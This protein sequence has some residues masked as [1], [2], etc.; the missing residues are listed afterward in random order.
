MR[1]TKT[2]AREG[3]GIKGSSSDRGLKQVSCITEKNRNQLITGESGITKNEIKREIDAHEK[4]IS[5]CG[6]RSLVVAF[7]DP[8]FSLHSFQIGA[9]LCTLMPFFPSFRKKTKVVEKSN[10]DTSQKN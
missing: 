7:V 8:N 2:A 9:V 10:D 4:P 6:F 5:N 1:G 3:G